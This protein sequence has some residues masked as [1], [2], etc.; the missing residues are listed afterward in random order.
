M[1]AHQQQGEEVVPEDKIIG[2]ALAAPVPAISLLAIL[3][4]HS[5]NVHVHWVVSTIGLMVISFAADE[6]AYALNGYL[7]DSHAVYASSR[8]AFNINFSTQSN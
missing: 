4:N 5:P 8:L 1:R 3:L 2:F 7:A 6:F